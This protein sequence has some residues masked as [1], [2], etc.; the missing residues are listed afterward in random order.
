MNTPN[1]PNLSLLPDHWIDCETHIPEQTSQT[2]PAFLFVPDVSHVSPRGVHVL[3]K[4]HA[5]AQG[6]RMHQ[7]HGHRTVHPA[8]P[9]WL[10][11]GHPENIWGIIGLKKETWGISRTEQR[12]ISCQEAVMEIRLEQNEETCEIMDMRSYQE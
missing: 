2:L 7:V 4:G 10:C 8:V 5:P 9:T 1:A 11:P 3:G 12:D 6:M